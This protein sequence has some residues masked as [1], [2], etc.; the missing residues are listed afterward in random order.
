MQCEWMS[1]RPRVRPEGGEVRE[2]RRKA[3]KK[4]GVGCEVSH[5][6]EEVGRPQAYETIWRLEVSAAHAHPMRRASLS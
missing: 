3:G 1:P 5:S 6:D 4:G 2:R